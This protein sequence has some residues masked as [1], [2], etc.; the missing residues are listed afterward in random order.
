MHRA[1]RPLLRAKPFT[2]CVN[3]FCDSVNPDVETAAELK[4]FNANKSKWS[5][6]KCTEI[7]ELLTLANQY[8][9]TSAIS[10]LTILNASARLLCAG[11]TFDE[12]QAQQLTSYLQ[13]MQSIFATTE[14]CIPKH[15][16][17]CMNLDRIWE[18][19]YVRRDA[20]HMQRLNLDAIKPKMFVKLFFSNDSEKNRFFCC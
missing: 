1:P 15:F 17:V 5:K 14:V 13:Q 16:D 8:P 2:D 19:T 11:P 18:F 20:S 12:D 6:L 7:Q 3:Y 10:N 4:Q 9:L